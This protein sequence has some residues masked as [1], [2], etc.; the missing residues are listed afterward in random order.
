[1]D[2]SHTAGSY[3]LN[4]VRLQ[5]DA[6]HSNEAI[7][8][9]WGYNLSYQQ[10]ECRPKVLNYQRNVDHVVLHVQPE[11]HMAEVPAAQGS[12]R[13]RGSESTQRRSYD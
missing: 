13:H 11:D 3:C 12:R 7:L 6:H 8:H 2:Y 4:L 5:Q 10:T 1:M 9:I